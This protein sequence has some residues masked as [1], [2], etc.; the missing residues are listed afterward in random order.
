MNC[1]I[2]LYQAQRN[3]EDVNAIDPLFSVNIDH[4][5]SPLMAFKLWHNKNGHKKSLSL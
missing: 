3:N 2:L 5:V 1:T 4:R